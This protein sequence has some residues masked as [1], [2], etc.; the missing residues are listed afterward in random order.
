MSKVKENSGIGNNPKTNSVKKQ[1]TK[2]N[3]PLSYYRGQD[4]RT[5]PQKDKNGDIIPG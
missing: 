1:I 3:L 2:K 4:K 5:K